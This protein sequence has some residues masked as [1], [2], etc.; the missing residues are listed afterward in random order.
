MSWCLHNNPLVCTD[1]HV[2]QLVHYWF[3]K[4]TFIHTHIISTYIY[5]YMCVCVS[6]DFQ[7]S[8]A[9]ALRT[10]QN[11]VAGRGQGWA[12][13]VTRTHERICRTDYSLA[14]EHCWRC[15]QLNP[16]AHLQNDSRSSRWQQRIAPKKWYLHRQCPAKASP[17]DGQDFANDQTSGMTSSWSEHINMTAS[18]VVWRSSL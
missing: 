6:A 17:K 13:H 18:L 7:K 14:S 9:L 4:Y 2:S 12:T 16:G 11:A 5:I 10:L 8:S 1:S 3:D 15:L